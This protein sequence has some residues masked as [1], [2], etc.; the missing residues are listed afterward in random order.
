MYRKLADAVRRAVEGGA[1]AG[2]DRMPS[3]RQLADLLAVSRTTVVAAYDDLRENGVVESMR[4]SG[5]R[6]ARRAAGRGPSDGRVPG[7][8][9]A[10]IFQRLIDGPGEL[11]S[12]ACAAEPGD[13]GLLEVMREVAE[14]DMPALL[15]SQGFFPTGLPVCREAVAN[16]LTSGGFPTAPDQVL[17]TT[18]A[19]QALALIAELYL[20][21]GDRVLVESPSWP[22]CFDVFQAAGAELVTV[23]LDDEGAR[24]DAFA[25]ACIDYEPTLAYVMPTYHNP[26]GTLMSESR[27]RKL[28]EIATRTGVPIVE[29]N[30]YLGL[31][32]AEPYDAPQPPPL[33]SFAGPGGE[34]LSIGSLGKAVWGGLRIGWVRAP[35]EI[36]ERLARRKVLADL[37][38]PVFEQAVAARLLPR[39]D[40]I[41]SERAAHLRPQLEALERLLREQLPTWR[42]RRPDGGPAIWVELPP[43]VDAEV[44][45]QVA[46]RH[47]VEVIPGSAMMF[48]TVRSNHIRMP[49]TF[50]EPVLV[51]LVD[52]LARAWTELNRHGPVESRPVQRL[53]L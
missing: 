25:A 4:G 39:L 20:T 52:R 35:A 23:P 19:Q 28:A 29:D 10:T 49:Y 38:S 34:V 32:I 14:H 11:I 21:R 36:I 43:G 42:W 18:G 1:L 8:R 7:G 41:Q 53:V 13:Q 12:L 5:T 47:G 2:G 30:A 9:G 3:E 16:Y 17:M 26:T 22:G 45:A 46:L 48:D 6:I 37:S 44:Y 31:R 15:Q 27:R 50:P 33:G 51:E 24:A 40:Q